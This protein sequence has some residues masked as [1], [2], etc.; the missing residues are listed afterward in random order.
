MKTIQE[1]LSCLD[2]EYLYHEEAA[3]GI[4]LRRLA[5][6]QTLSEAGTKLTSLI[7][8]ADGCLQI[9]SHSQEGA[10]GT[11][12][13][14]KPPRFLGDI[15]YF[16]Q[17]PCLHRIIAQSDAVL[18]C[19]SLDY[20]RNCLEQ[21]VRFYRLMCRQLTE[22]LYRTSFS[23]SRS[24]LQPAKNRL[25]AWLLSHAGEEA[26]LRLIQRRV[27]EDLGISVRHAG[28]LIGELQRAG[29]LIK[30]GT[31][32]YGLPDPSALESLAEGASTADR[33]PI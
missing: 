23:Y 21:D 10:Y 12:A 24:L 31:K 19:F 26:Q 17:K 2:L 30:I 4:R 25:A 11:V 9:L 6:G 8:L 33:I 3:N 15:E 28:R 29:L 22:K 7:L 16:Q 1:Y 20:V 32:L 13:E 18:L 27:S 5:A 14:A